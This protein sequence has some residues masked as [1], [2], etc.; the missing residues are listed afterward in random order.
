MSEKQATK[1]LIKYCN[2]KIKES[3]IKNGHYSKV[4]KALK[5]Q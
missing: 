1:N 4:K 5:A 3:G 2:K